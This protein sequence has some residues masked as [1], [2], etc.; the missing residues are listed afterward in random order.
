MIQCEVDSSVDTVCSADE[1]ARRHVRAYTDIVPF[2][3]TSWTS[4]CQ[5]KVI[6]RHIFVSLVACFE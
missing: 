6:V 3:V 5:V 4:L 2:P 1:R